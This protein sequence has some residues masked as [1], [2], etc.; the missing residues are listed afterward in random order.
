VDG[1]SADQ[2][3]KKT[4]IEYEL[5]Q[6]AKMVFYGGSASAP[7]IAPLYFEHQFMFELFDR[8]IEHKTGDYRHFPFAV[9]PVHQ[10]YVTMWILD[11]LRGLWIQKLI[12]ETKRK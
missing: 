11:Y 2:S 3:E 9:S 10:P 1:V 12:D 4:R 6:V 7:E 8:I 5:R